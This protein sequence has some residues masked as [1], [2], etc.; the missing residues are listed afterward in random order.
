MF[1]QKVNKQFDR[2]KYYMYRYDL[3]MTNGI[4]KMMPCHLFQLRDVMGVYKS[5]F[6][7]QFY[8]IC[9]NLGKSK[10]QKKFI[11]SGLKTVDIMTEWSPKRQ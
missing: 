4:I 8:S 7:L 9:T 2:E 11:L 10:I 1:R 6:Y 3:N 5:N